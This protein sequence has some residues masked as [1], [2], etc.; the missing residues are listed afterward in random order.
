M[1]IPLLV[2]AFF[3]AEQGVKK[4]V[5]VVRASA[6]VGLLW[7]SS[8]IIFNLSLLHTSVA[9]NTV[10][11]STTSVFTFIFSLLILQ[12]P[13]RRRSFVAAML[14]CLGCAVVAAHTPQ[15]LAEG[16]ITNSYVGDAL[17]LTAAAMFAC[18]SVLLGKVAPEGMEINV[19]MG[20][21]GLL[22]LA[23]APGLLFVAH[24]GGLE[25]FQAP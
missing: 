1:S 4:M 18:A 5:S 7:L 3:H 9:T 15:N 16:A 19:Y 12:D 8:Q 20:M 22:S 6:T 2:P 17:A 24:V 10:L 23:Y 21:N 14:S 11:S 13:F 25:S